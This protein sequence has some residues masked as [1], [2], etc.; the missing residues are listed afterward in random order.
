MESL[1]DYLDILEDLLDSS[2]AVPFS[3]NIAVDK[4]RIYEIVNEIRLNIPSEIRQAQKIIEDHDRIVIN[5]KSKASGLI[6]ETENTAQL[7]TNSHEIYKRAMEQASEVMDE[8][9]K[10]ARDVRLNAMD[11][12]DELLSK[13]EAII[14]EAMNNLNEQHRVMDDYFSQTVDVLYQNRL[15]L[16]G[17]K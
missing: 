2:K 13:T 9:K 17:D 16:R 12:A 11:Y 3:K 14:R 8:A 1:L 15:E 7:M 10:N 4:Q 5:A 6:K